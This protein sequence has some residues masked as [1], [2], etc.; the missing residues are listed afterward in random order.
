LKSAAIGESQGV[1]VGRDVL[2]P[3]MERGFTLAGFD[4]V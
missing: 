2:L 4:G 1:L 3:M